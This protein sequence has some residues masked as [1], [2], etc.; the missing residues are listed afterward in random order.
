MIKK[1]ISW[2]MPT[3]TEHYL[4]SMAEML[5]EVEQVVMILAV[6][7][8]KGEVESCKLSIK[9]EESIMDSALVMVGACLGA[10]YYEYL[11][12]LEAEKKEDLFA[13][14]VE[15]EENL[16]KA[17]DP[18]DDNDADID[19]VLVEEPTV[20]KVVKNEESDKQT[21]EQAEDLQEKKDKIASKDITTSTETV[22]MSEKE[23]KKGKTSDTPYR[24]S[25][26]TILGNFMK[27]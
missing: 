24:K 1:N 9:A 20:L 4:E 5:S 27:F 15:P 17:A 18:G 16:F 8:A 26:R 21:E 22:E 19:T 14:A 11:Q 2:V 7:S 3:P 25:L 13:K 6:K 23:A 10:H 12:E